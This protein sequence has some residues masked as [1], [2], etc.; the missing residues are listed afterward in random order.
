M[1]RLPGCILT[2][3]LNIMFIQNRIFMYPV[4]WIMGCY[5]TL[6]R[7]ISILDVII[8]SNLQNHR[9]AWGIKT[10]ILKF[11]IFTLFAIKD[12]EFISCLTKWLLFIVQPSIFPTSHVSQSCWK[13]ITVRSHERRGVLDHRQLDCVQRLVNRW[14]PF[15]K[16]L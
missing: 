1:Q 10:A 2:L 11:H 6:G 16:G 3:I 4:Y 5:I 9:S 15:T 8:S 7:L 14:I 12:V 13:F